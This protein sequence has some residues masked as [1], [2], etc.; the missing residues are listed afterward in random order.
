M[1][2]KT[3]T[4]IVFLTRLSDTELQAIADDPNET[5]QTM[6]GKPVRVAAA[7]ELALRSRKAA[8]GTSRP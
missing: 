6:T 1:A 2:E 7:D 5:R 8:A 3:A 4:E